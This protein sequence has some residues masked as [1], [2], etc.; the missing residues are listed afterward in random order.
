MRLPL[1]VYNRTLGAL[2]NRPTTGHL[3]KQLQNGGADG[4][5][6]DI[7][8]SAAVPESEAKARKEK[9]GKK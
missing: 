7:L 5:Q 4:G 6:Q 9:A 1:F 8:V 2:I 3:V